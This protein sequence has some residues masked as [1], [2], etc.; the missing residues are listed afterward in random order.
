M[1]IDRKE[2]IQAILKN[3]SENLDQSWLKYVSEILYTGIVE[4]NTKGHVKTYS[5]VLQSKQG[6]TA[7]LIDTTVKN[8]LPVPGTYIH[9]HTDLTGAYCACKFFEQ[10][11]EAVRVYDSCIYVANELQQKQALPERALKSPVTVEA[12]ETVSTWAAK[13]KERLEKQLKGRKITLESQGW[14]PWNVNNM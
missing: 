2:I 3:N 10:A 13:Q 5:A 14:D 11:V 1:E 9:Q 12:N 6:L 4:R 7:V 8:V